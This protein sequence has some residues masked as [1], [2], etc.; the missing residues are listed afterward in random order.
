[1]AGDNNLSEDMITALKGMK[2]VANSD[3]INLIALY[4]SNYPPVPIKVYEFSKK[5]APAARGTEVPLKNFEYSILNPCP[6]DP[7]REFFKILDFVPMVIGEFPAE[8]YG[9]ILSG[10]SDG[11]IGR[12]LLR[13]EN[14]PI[15][16]DVK[17]LASV[18]KRVR[19][20]N[21]FGKPKKFDLLGF[22]GCL[23]N[24]LEIGY[25]L[26]RVAKVMVASEGNIPT[27]GW[28][29]K[30]IL[31]AVKGICPL[32]PS[33]FAI[34][35]VK[36]FGD[37][38]EDYDIS[39]RSVNISAC[40]L[41]K[42]KPLVRAIYRF[43]EHLLAILN[44]LSKEEDE[45][46]EITDETRKKKIIREHFID[47][48]QLAHLSA[49]SFMHNQA[50]DILDFVLNL[51]AQSIKRLIEIGYLYDEKFENEVTKAI[52]VHLGHLF[53]DYYEIHRAVGIRRPH[54]HVDGYIIENRF[55]GKEYQFSTG[56]SIFFPWTRLALGMVEEQYSHL[57]F[58]RW[59]MWLKLIQKYTNLTCRN[60]DSDFTDKLRNT[61]S[62]QMGTARFDI[63]MLAISLYT[64]FAH[65]EFVGKEFVGKEFVGKGDMDAFY[66]YFSEFRNYNTDFN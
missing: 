53:C 22:D 11:I 43:A 29:Y 39:G 28:N 55:P 44:L 1:M 58:N 19:P 9:L 52:I 45:S 37:F 47:C 10:H 38:N 57:R 51:L 61:P 8:K 26:R 48:L 3:N 64:L 17:G 23:M 30:E 4:D 18:L 21:E 33:Q 36:Q 49:Q 5:I 13:D 62:V 2:C 12:T 35:I 31:E 42:V 15:S 65:K 56:A 34:E 25:E 54:E 63:S 6:G 16:L 59:R 32:E 60:Q 24:M 50:V 41:T 7:R 20:T 14:P 66:S 46:D 40:D 27:S